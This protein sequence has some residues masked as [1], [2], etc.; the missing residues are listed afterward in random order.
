M[1]AYWKLLNLLGAEWVPSGRLVN[2]ERLR[3]HDKLFMLE[4]VESSGRLVG[5]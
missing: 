5:A 4:V 2:S 1:G 3:A